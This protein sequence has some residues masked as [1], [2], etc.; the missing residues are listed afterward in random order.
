MATTR[1]QISYGSRGDEV[2][3]LQTA[4]N[5]N[6]YNLSVDGIFGSKT[7]AAVKD[8]QTKNK[9][10]VDGIVGKNTWGSL[11]PTTTT[12]TT[13]KPAA[14]ITKPT[15][16]T[17][18]S[19]KTTTTKSAAQTA[20]ES[21]PYKES[22]TVAQAKAALQAQLNGKPDA[23]QSSYQQQIN[24]V[25]N[26]ILNRE[27]FSYDLNGDA[28]YQQYKD[29]YT[30][31]GK[32]AMMDTMGQA[33]ALTGGYGNSYAQSVGQQTYQGY[34]QQL[35]DKVPEL[36]QLALDK[37]NMEGDDLLN[38]YSL[39][40]DRENTEYGRYRDDVSDYYTNLDFAYNRYNNERDFDY[41]QHRDG[42]SDKMWQ[43]EFDEAFRQYTEQMAYQQG[44]DKIS[45]E[46]WQKEFEEAQRQFN[47]AKGIS[48]GGSSGGS[49]SSPKASDKN[50]DNPSKDTTKYTNQQKT[51]A[52]AKTGSIASFD[53]VKA[54]S[55]TNNDD[56]WDYL[57][58]LVNKGSLSYD[59]AK[60]KYSQ[61]AITKNLNTS[62]STYA[63]GTGATGGYNNK[64]AT[65]Y[66]WK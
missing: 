24:D 25:L 53:P 30:T 12:T 58:G 54:K 63:Y 56:L 57:L 21:V 37:Y 49:S 2:K 40:T 10:Q 26:K 20:L 17:S 61:Y 43:T 46:Q 36:Y 28:L 8:Y 14:T 64:T 1:N 9:L 15:T 33:A 29:Q 35:N 60:K 55:F 47:V 62:G 27:K 22:D 44:R 42:V 52:T 4:L 18:S 65:D 3:E 19:T 39:Y 23:Y 34:L 41:G 16:T 51:D 6:G 13:T 45:D 50:S 7:Q 11:F 38:Q 48:S 66:Y 59:E 32:Q 5:K 31:Q